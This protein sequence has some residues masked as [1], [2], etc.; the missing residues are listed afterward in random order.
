MAHKA[1]GF[2][3]AGGALGVAVHSRVGVA[4]HPRVGV[5][6]H[7]R[8]GEPPIGGHERV[9]VPAPPRLRAPLPVAPACIL[10]G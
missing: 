4:V 8:V 1:G 9:E 5:A 7:P 10:G 3:E 6:V 2:E